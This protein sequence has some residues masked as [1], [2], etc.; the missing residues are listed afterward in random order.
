MAV[1][2]AGESS[3]FLDLLARYRRDIYSVPADWRLH[4]ESLEPVAYRQNDEAM[5]EQ[6]LDTYRKY[7]HLEAN[8][9]P[10][11]RTDSV[12]P[13]LEIMRGQVAQVEEKVVR[14]NIG[15]EQS[16]L[17]I[18]EVSRRASSLYAGVSS[19]EASHVHSMDARNWLYEFYERERLSG[20]SHKVIGR[21]LEIL[22]RAEEFE[23][24]IK[25]KWPTKKRFGIEGAESALVLIS[26]ILQ[27]S[28]DEGVGEVVIGG[29][30]RGRLAL[31][32]TVLGKDLSELLRE[33]KGIDVTAEDPAY[34]G[35]VPYHNGLASRFYAEGRE[36]DVKLLPHPSHLSV[37]APVAVGASRARQ[38]LVNQRGGAGE[39]TV[40]PLLLH[41]DAAFSGQGLISE[42]LQLG[43]LDGYTVGGAIHVVVNNQIG[44]TTTPREGRS[45]HYP[46]DIGKSVGI[47]ILHVNGDYPEAVA[48]IAHVAA[49]WRKHWKSDIII[50]LVCYRRNG[51]NELDEPSFTQPHMCN[52]IDML[53]P[54][55]T[56]FTEKIAR[57]NPA[58]VVQAEDARKCFNKSMSDAYDSLSDV[59]EI[60]LP[61]SPS[62]FDRMRMANSLPGEITPATGVAR[63]AL[64]KLALQICHLPD[65]F[66]VH[67]KVRQFYAKR[68]SSLE[69]DSGMNMATA[70]ALAFASLLAE[71][72]SVRLSG[73]DSVRGTFTQRHCAVHD[74]DHYRISMP[75]NAAALRDN[76]RF[77]AV[78]SPLSEYG[79]L[80]FEYG[81]SLAAASSCL[82]VWEAQF[83]DFLNGAQ[84]VVDQFISTAQAK[85]RMSSNMVIA[86]PHG[87][88][89]QGPDHS[90]ARLERL[91]QMAACENIVVANPS[92]PANLF[93]LYRRQMLAPRP[94]PLFLI[95]P[96]SL[97]RRIECISFLG[98]IES[99]TEF[100]K[101]LPSPSPKDV[102]RKI[103]FCSGK[104]YYD[105]LQA[106]QARTVDDIAIVRIEQLYPFPHE[107]VEEIL[108][109]FAGAKLNW[110]QEEPQNQG[111]WSFVRER[112]ADA[113]V[114]ITYVGR[115]Q[116][117]AA[118]G[119]S[120][121]RHEKEQANII[122]VAISD[123]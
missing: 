104:I 82:V 77:E 65:D 36:L 88:E 23:S 108:R 70:E 10:L 105:L 64:L 95:A 72:F 75:I 46:T 78:N 49:Q 121:A 7:G 62:P 27:R 69:Q 84:V 66:N 103:I 100:K 91:L 50:D 96:K 63:A 32:A 110:C 41:T 112:F 85:W 30:H 25:M 39:A 99:G 48:Q 116:M 33:I 101:V 83:G 67:P 18:G 93:H 51:H 119:G 29:M 107:E 111:A 5:A 14:V 98:E 118:A 120:I 1:T 8:L 106:Q 79:V 40:L 13:E 114:A 123:A 54:L 24:F 20:A 60:A 38:Q 94:M 109:R 68:L 26:E 6:L 19:L 16:S 115:P 43:A 15:G 17:P 113:G 97:L 21:T 45:S 44:F 61:S 42:M 9:D 28:A 58:I 80:S 102:C 3:Y 55:G 87:L 57:S 76:G 74:I 56:S 73:Q 71:G 122:S 92:T 117:A 53:P 59:S 11:G 35:D 12:C 34:T 90:S 81:Y 2:Y 22:L 4:F 52:K 37:V 89:G 31:L 47:P 86:L